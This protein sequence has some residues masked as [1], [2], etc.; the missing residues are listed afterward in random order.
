MKDT[1]TIKINK[2]TETLTITRILTYTITHINTQRRKHMQKHTKHI[3][4]EIYKQTQIQKLKN[5]N[6]HT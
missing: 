6:K 2:Y 3:H 5:T 4:T 1:T